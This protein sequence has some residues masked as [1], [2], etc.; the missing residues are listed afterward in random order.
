M[1]IFLSVAFLTTGSSIALI[2]VS[3]RVTSS[4]GFTHWRVLP[5]GPHL[6]GQNNRP[7]ASD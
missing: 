6:S 7:L 1:A 2:Y 5:P 3:Q 4:S